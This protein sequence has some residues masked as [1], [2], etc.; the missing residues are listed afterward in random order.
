M[1]L[2]NTG[3]VRHWEGLT[4]FEIAGLTCKVIFFPLKNKVE[5]KNDES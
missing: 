5:L 3:A 4:L 2:R 1:Y